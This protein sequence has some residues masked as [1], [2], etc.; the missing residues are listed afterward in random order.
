MFALQGSRQARAVLALAVV[1]VLGLL[2]SGIASSPAQT[3]TDRCGD[4]VIDRTA[5]DPT[6]GDPT[7]VVIGFNTPTEGDDVIFGT[8]GADKINGDDGD[9]ELYGEA[10]ADDLKGDVGDDRLFGGDDGDGLD[11]GQGNDTL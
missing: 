4:K 5:L 7:I 10:G 9:D 8:N 1:L 2:V 3:A 11:G 6:G